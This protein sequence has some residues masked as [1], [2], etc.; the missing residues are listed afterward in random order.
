MYPAVFLT[1]NDLSFYEDGKFRA[2][3]NK[4]LYEL[5]TRRIKLKNS[6]ATALKTWGIDPEHLDIPGNI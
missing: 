5:S 2:S 4:G 3:V 6:F 1:G